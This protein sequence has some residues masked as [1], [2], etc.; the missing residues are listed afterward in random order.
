MTMATNDDLDAR[1]LL[2]LDDEDLG[3]VDDSEDEDEGTDE[4]DDS[5]DTEDNAEGGGGDEGE[6]DNPEDPKEPVVPALTGK[7]L[8]DALTQDEEAQ[9]VF[10][11][12]VAEYQRQQAAEAASQEEREAFDKMVADEDWEGIGKAVIAKQQRDAARESVAEEIRAAEYRPVYQELL[13]QPEMQTLTAEDREA[14]HVSKYP[15]SAAHIKA[16][17]EFI[18]GKRAEAAIEAEVQKRV[19]A[20]READKNREGAS[21]AK[22]PSLAGRAPTPLGPVGERANSADLIR[23]GL[24][25][26]INPDADDDDE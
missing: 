19:A 13:S 5:S 1:G 17:T 21:K 4:E 14:L 24:R 2:P 20:A 25:G 8:I 7:A 11:S 9:S 3:D 26:I 23:A 18:L 22:T 10:Q 6:G 16:M 15:S 12:M